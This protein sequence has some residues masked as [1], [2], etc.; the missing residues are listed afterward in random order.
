MN[1]DFNKI[2]SKVETLYDE[3][4]QS[5]PNSSISKKVTLSRFKKILENYE[6]EIQIK[7]ASPIDLIPEIEGKISTYRN[8]FREGS[9]LIN[10]LRNDELTN[11]NENESE[12][13]VLNEMLQNTSQLHQSPRDQWRNFHSVDSDSD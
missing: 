6:K 13:D 8:Q 5:Y 1:L 11:D 10:K 9:K 2:L 12:M 3:C 4:L 7:L